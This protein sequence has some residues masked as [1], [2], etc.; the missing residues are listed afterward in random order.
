M[1]PDNKLI[2]R[3]TRP[4]LGMSSINKSRQPRTLSR[5]SH[6]PSIGPFA[7]TASVGRMFPSGNSDYDCFK[8]PNASNGAGCSDRDYAGNNPPYIDNCNREGLTGTRGFGNSN[9]LVADEGPSPFGCNVCGATLHSRTALKNHIMQKHEGKDVVKC[10]HCEKAFTRP[11][12]LRKHIDAS[13]DER[14]GEYY[15]DKCTFKNRDIEVFNQHVHLHK[16][17]QYCQNEF[18]QLSRHEPKCPY[19]P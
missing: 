9:I 16:V 13:H 4:E 2:S 18:S 5:T 12:Q 1:D 17:C 15:C 14:T 6:L 3:K 7:E 10:P 19:R 8:A 11:S